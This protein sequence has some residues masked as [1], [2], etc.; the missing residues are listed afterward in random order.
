MPERQPSAQLSR[1]LPHIGTFKP[2]RHSFRTFKPEENAEMK[3]G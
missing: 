3:I 2:G 1:N